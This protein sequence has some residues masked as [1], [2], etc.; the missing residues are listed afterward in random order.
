VGNTFY[1]FMNSLMHGQL[2]REAVPH[3]GCAYHAA[4]T[5][6]LKLGLCRCGTVTKAC[7]GKG[8]HAAVASGRGPFKCGMHYRCSSCVL[9]KSA[10]LK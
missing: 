3:R 1:I 2:S 8:I 7:E 6:A 10:V 4:P 5:Y 9:L